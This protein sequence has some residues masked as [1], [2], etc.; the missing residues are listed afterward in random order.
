V[1]ERARPRNGAGGPPSGTVPPTRAPIIVPPQLARGVIAPAANDN[2]EPPGRR[3]AR[4]GWVV[5]LL[6][7]V[8]LYSMIVNG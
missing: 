8:L 5:L 4:F 1:V 2:P 6:A 7:G 3:L